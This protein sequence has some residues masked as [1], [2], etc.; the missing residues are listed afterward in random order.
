MPEKAGAFAEA[1]ERAALP[2]RTRLITVA[3]ATVIS[4]TAVIFVVRDMAKQPVLITSLASSIFL[5]YHQP[6]NEINRF[7]PIVAGHLI[8]VTVGYL[9]TL[10]LPMPYISAAVSVAAAVIILHRFIRRRHLGRYFGFE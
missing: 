2:E 3:I 4:T 7:T 8:A 6:L 5:L 10:L 9:A 1:R